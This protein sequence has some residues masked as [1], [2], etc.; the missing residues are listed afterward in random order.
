MASDNKN[1]RTEVLDNLDFDSIEQQWRQQ[2]M[3]P[4]AP[5]QDAAFPPPPSGGFP[6][7]PGGGFPPPPGGGFPPPPGGGFPPLP[8]MPGFP[9]GA[10]V[11]GGD[12]TAAIDVSNMELEPDMSTI[13][14]S[15]DQLSASLNSDMGLGISDAPTEALRLEDVNVSL[16]GNNKVIVGDNTSNATHQR[17]T[18]AMQKVE[19]SPDQV[20]IHGTGSHPIYQGKEEGS[21]TGMIVGIVIVV[22]L[23][24]GGGIGAAIMLSSDGDGDAANSAT[25][26]PAV[27]PKP[28]GVVTAEQAA[29]LSLADA[30]NETQTKTSDEDFFAMQFEL[31]PFAGEG[32]LVTVTG[33]GVFFNGL[34]L[35]TLEVA[36]TPMEPLSEALSAA[37]DK[38]LPVLVVPH[39]G[40]TFKQI[41]AVL[42]STRADG[43]KLYLSGTDS[44]NLLYGIPLT[45]Y[46]WDEESSKHED[47]KIYIEVLTD[48]IKVTSPNP[49]YA[50]A[51]KVI[52]EKKAAAELE[53]APKEGEDKKAAKDGEKK[54]AKGEDKKDTK[55]DAAP[56]DG[57]KAVVEAAPE[58]PT[59]PKTITQ[60]LAFPSGT[61]PQQSELATALKKIHEENSK[62]P[63]VKISAV[64]DVSVV[65]LAQVLIA[66]HLNEKK[67][68]FETLLIEPMK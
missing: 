41:Y 21:K 65:K 3:G 67:T 23:L 2:K 20:Q 28:E 5:P 12:A 64:G 54:E 49:E 38:A 8:P 31:E 42:L 27:K 25:T 30:W 55:G 15:M 57:D 47:S 60:E 7:P 59:V 50:A 58:E 48:A 24:V 6:P 37:E 43:R 45:P 29:E 44:N 22:L 51:L 53:A 36:A 19:R 40:L 32:L 4:G 1:G 18:A 39:E 56:K 62:T 11:P 9:G 10:G 14:L 52:A 66:A 13:N 63:R 26:K 33:N 61:D 68:L 35:G 46:K 17:A 34:K 16:K